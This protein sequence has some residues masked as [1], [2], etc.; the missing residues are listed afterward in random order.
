MLAQA[1]IALFCVPQTLADSTEK[2]QRVTWRELPLILTGEEQV[3]IR[4]PGGALRGDVVSVQKT[5][6]HLHDITMATDRLRYPSGAEALILRDAVQEIRFET[7]QGKMRNVG[8]AIGAIGG[9]FLV[10]RMAVG[11]SGA[12]SEGGR[13]M[14]ALAGMIAGSVGFGWLGHRLGKKADLKTIVITIAN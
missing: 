12:Q 2:H 13:A 11:L 1:S 9:L 14:A 10:P 5:G 3:T 7:L 8:T 4:V 6:I